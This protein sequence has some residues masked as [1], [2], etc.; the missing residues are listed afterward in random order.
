MFSRFITWIK[1]MFQKMFN[2][3]SIK[4]K[5]RV[6]I[7]VSEDMSAAIDLWAKMYTNKADWFDEK[8]MIAGLNLPASI[9]AEIARLVTIEMQLK[10]EGSPRADF[11]DKQIEPVRDNIRIYT[12]KA[13]A[14]GGLFAKPYPK[15]DRV[16]ID[17]I[18]A[19]MGYPV[20]FDSSGAITAA[21]F[22]ERKTVGKVYFTRLEYHHMETDGYHIDNAAYRSDN[23]S[24]IGLETTLDAVAEWADLLPYSIVQNI[25]Q[26][27][28][29]Y[30]KV[31]L[32]NNIDTTS[33]LGV[34]V[35]SRAVSLIEQA[36]R[37]FAR[38]IWEYEGSELAVH[39]DV[40][41]FKPDENTGKPI[42]PK[43]R[44]RLYRT[45][46]SSG[47][48]DMPLDT[49]S[50]TIRDQSLFNGLDKIKREIEF[51]CNLAYGTLS[52]PQSVD[53]TA[54]EIKS[55]K[56]RSY[57]FVSDMQK[58]LKTFLDD[59]IYSIDIYTTLYSLAPTGKYELKAEFSDSIIIDTQKEFANRLQLLGAQAMQPWELRVWYLGETEEQA[60]EILSESPGSM[61]QL[62]KNITAKENGNANA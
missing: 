30:F 47:V 13:A 41:A 6:D 2:T 48:S 43:G 19:D 52:D 31:P 40:S 54:E 61:D 62:L 32:A 46:Q 1:E 34:S 44:E 14:L 28:F 60:K 51:A 3:S 16:L 39:A 57:A 22:A 24:G 11:I 50:P 23:E 33:P 37:Q 20:S 38:T 25:D 17:F 49:F 53:K 8:N 36:D 27:L 7:S 15:G 18:P 35:Y 58:S 10:V 59:L 45:L 42:I 12:E 9:S 21:V 26:P 5:L 29:A 4:E 55:S 56:Q